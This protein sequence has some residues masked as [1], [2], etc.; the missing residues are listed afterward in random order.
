M[1]ADTYWFETR[2]GAK[3]AADLHWRGHHLP[4]CQSS[5]L[6]PQFLEHG[7]FGMGL[8]DTQASWLWQRG[9]TLGGFR[10]ICE[11]SVYRNPLSEPF[12]GEFGFL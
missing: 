12:M 4:L 6:F 5:S 9:Q 7:L 10:R 3:A 8:D 1:A 11:H 2:K